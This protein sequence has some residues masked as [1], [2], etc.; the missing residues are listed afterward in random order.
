MWCLLQDE[1]YASQECPRCGHRHKP[2][3]RLYACPACKFRFHRDGDGAINIRRKY[4]GCGAVVGAM[5]SPTG[6]W[7]HP[8]RRVR[9]VR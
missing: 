5:A 8:H 1:A 7:W 4:L 6:M 9:V 3:G 2:R